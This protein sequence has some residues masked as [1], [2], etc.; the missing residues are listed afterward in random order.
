MYRVLGR[1]LQTG[2]LLSLAALIIG[3][4]LSVAKDGFSPAVIPFEE[5]LSGLSGFL[6]AAWLTLGI[7]VLLVTPV[8][9]L[10]V[11]AVASGIWRDRVSLSAA[12]V[13]LFILLVSI[14]I[15]GRA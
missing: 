14:L 3:L 10:L 15:V 5:L 13:I 1:V 9:A 4:A 11:V 8:V 6:P 2:V 7:I 12:L